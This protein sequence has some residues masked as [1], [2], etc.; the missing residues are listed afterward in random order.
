[1]KEANENYRKLTL[2]FNYLLPSA[3]IRFDTV[4]LAR[5]ILL[6]NTALLHLMRLQSIV[7][8]ISMEPTTISD[9]EWI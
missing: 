5:D 4:T 1:M 7:C 2:S 6:Y 9:I 8:S 3:M